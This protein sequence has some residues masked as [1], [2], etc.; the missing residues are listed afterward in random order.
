[1]AHLNLTQTQ[2]RLY[3]RPSMIFFEYA[4]LGA[5]V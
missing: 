4:S 2:T 5:R 1:M 3:D